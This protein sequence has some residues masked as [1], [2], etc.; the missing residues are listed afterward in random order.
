MGLRFKDFELVNFGAA[1]VGLA[2]KGGD[3]YEYEP[4]KMAEFG[5]Q[6]IKGPLKEKIGFTVSKDYFESVGVDHTSFDITGKQG[7]L[8]VDL[9]TELKE[10]W[11]Q[12]DMV[13]N[14]YTSEHVK[15]EYSCFKN[16]HNF[17]KLN[18]PIICAVP[19]KIVG[20]DTVITI[21]I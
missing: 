14:F 15:D 1:F 9:G 4:F 17:C 19:R 2:N 18:H 21:M 13:T 16:M 10:Y 20:P 7:S 11:G 8:A 6:N 12:Y 5:S 3:S